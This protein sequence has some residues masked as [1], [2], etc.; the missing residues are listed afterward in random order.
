MKRG[1]L[2]ELAHAFGMNHA[3]SW[4]PANRH[5]ISTMQGHLCYLSALDAGYLRHFYPDPRGKDHVNIVVSSTTRFESK[6]AIFADDNPNQLYVDAEGRLVDL[7]TGNP[8]VI[9]VA[10]FNTGNK[11][12]PRDVTATNRLFLKNRTT[13]Q[14]IELH[15]WPIASMPALSQ[16]QWRGPIDFSPKQTGVKL[17]GSWA[18]TFEVNVDDKW[19]ELTREDN[20]ISYP[21]TIRSRPQ[22]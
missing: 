14:E 12:A 2:H 7:R 1:V 15:R 21:V 10:W 20:R 8:P 22:K 17:N 9:Q 3:K 6:K 19:P 5:L 16:D 13:K 18:F 11:S 4:S